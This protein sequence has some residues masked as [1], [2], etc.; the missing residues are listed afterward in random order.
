[1]IRVFNKIIRVFKNK[2][3]SFDNSVQNV[4]QKQYGSPTED[5]LCK[6]PSK[7]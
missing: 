1:M 4:S 3:F 2:T 5:I 6:N 7:R